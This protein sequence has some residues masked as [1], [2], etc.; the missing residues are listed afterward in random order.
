MTKTTKSFGIFRIE[1]K[2]RAL[3]GSFALYCVPGTDLGVFTLHVAVGDKSSYL[4]FTS[5][6]TEA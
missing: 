5:E 2:E 6:E 3:F 4:Y 1:K